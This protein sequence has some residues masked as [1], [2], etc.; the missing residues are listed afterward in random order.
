[1]KYIQQKYQKSFFSYIILVTLYL[2]VGVKIKFHNNHII[3]I[4]IELMNICLY[5][6]RNPHSSVGACSFKSNFR[7]LINSLNNL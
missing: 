6:K 7:S 2:I 1:M 4:A 5:D 3:G